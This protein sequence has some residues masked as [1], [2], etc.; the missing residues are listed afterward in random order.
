MQ[1]YSTTLGCL[2]RFV[3]WYVATVQHVA[4]T[5]GTSDCVEL[6]SQLFEY[7]VEDPRV[8]NG[9]AAQTTALQVGICR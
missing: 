2:H 4:G 3:T 1:W 9:D 6:A 8:F 5:R 7:F